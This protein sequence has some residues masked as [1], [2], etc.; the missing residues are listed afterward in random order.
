MHISASS[1]STSATSA[2][3]ATKCRLQVDVL[4][5]ER[6]LFEPPEG[7][8]QAVRMIAEGEFGWQEYFMPL[9]H[10]IEHTDHYLVANDFESYIEA[11]VCCLPLPSA[12]MTCFVQLLDIYNSYHAF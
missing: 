10:S 3:S 9:V 8:K 7:F 12:C 1:G 6:G 11:Q 5:A 4:R 2:T